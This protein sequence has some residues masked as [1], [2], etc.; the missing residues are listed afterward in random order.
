M[1]FSGESTH[2]EIAQMFHPC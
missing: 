2:P 1:L